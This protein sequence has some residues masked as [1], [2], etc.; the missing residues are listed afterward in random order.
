MK[1]HARTLLLWLVLG[2][3]SY[4]LARVTIENLPLPVVMCGGLLPILALSLT[5]WAF[6]ALPNR[7]L[8]RAGF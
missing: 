5:I 3:I 4:L 8:L 7:I 6:A 2:G 1:A